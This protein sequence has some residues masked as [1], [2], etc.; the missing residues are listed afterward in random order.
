VGVRAEARRI[1]VGTALTFLLIDVV[2]VPAGRIRP[3][4]LIDAAMEVGWI[5]AW[6]RSAP[7]P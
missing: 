4:Y 5:V 2:Y 3:T 1:G 6:S 7:R